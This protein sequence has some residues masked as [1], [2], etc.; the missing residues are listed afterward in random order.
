MKNKDFEGNGGR[1]LIV[2]R[3]HAVVIASRKRY[4][5]IFQIRIPDRPGICLNMYFFRFFVSPL[6]RWHAGLQAHVKQKQHAQENKD[7][8]T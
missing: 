5:N 4:E 1:G 7:I 6:C 8:Y 2:L 3:G